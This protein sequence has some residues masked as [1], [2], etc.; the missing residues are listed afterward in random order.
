MQMAERPM[1]FEELV[2]MTTRNPRRTVAMAAGELAFTE[3]GE[4]NSLSNIK[5]GTFDLLN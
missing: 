5:F 3:Q 4:F 1:T 2:E